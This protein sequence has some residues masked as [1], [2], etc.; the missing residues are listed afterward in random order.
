MIPIPQKFGYVGS[1]DNP[2]SE[3]AGKVTAIF[4]RAPRFQATSLTGPPLNPVNILFSVFRLIFALV[5]PVH[6]RR[7]YT[8][9]PAA[10]PS[11]VTLGYAYFE[12]G[13]TWNQTYGFTSIVP[14]VHMDTVAPVSL[15][16][17]G[18][19][20]AIFESWSPISTLY[21]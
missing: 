5:R 18:K 19:V 21:Q 6:P 1:I 8:F 20:F 15:P 11:P 9:S 7:I 4:S 10:S 17:P 16:H 13:T 12:L 14:N 2:V 3:S